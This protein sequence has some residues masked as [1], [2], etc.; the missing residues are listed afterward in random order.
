MLILL[1]FGVYP[2]LKQTDSRK[3]MSHIIT[4]HVFDKRRKIFLAP[5]KSVICKVSDFDIGFVCSYSGDNMVKF[6]EIFFG[7]IRKLVETLDIIL[8][9]LFFVVKDDVIVS[10]IE[11]EASVSL[12]E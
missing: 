6:L 9:K 10:L 3:D 11:N 8:V 5:I 7:K 2:K 1:F 12:L 4:L